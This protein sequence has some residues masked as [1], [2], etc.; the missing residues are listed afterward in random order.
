[1]SKI[2]KLTD[3]QTEMMAVYRDK[4]VK[5]GLSTEPT[6]QERAKTNLVDYYKAGDLA[7]PKTVIFAASPMAAMSI[8]SVLSS[9]T[10]YDK[11]QSILK[12]KSKAGKALANKLGDLQVALNAQERVAQTIHSSVM[13]FVANNTDI[14]GLGP[15]I[16]DVVRE[17][18][19]NTKTQWISN[20]AGGNLWPGW[21]S[22]YE[23]FNEE[24]NIPGLD[25]I[26]PTCALS[27]DV[28]WIFPYENLCVLVEKPIAINLDAA[29]RLHNNN[30]KSIE[31]SDGYGLYTLNGVSVPAWAVETPK[32]EIEPKKVLGLTN[33]E[34]RMALMRHVGL[35]KFLKELEAKQIDSLPHEDKAGNKYELYLLTVEGTTI[36]PYL[37]MKCPSSGREFLEGCGDINKYENIDTSIKTC[38]DALK[39]RAVKASNSLMTKFNLK[40]QYSA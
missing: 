2:E 37:Y 39:W 14:S 21:Q 28:G 36:G 23:F 16:M 17:E 4:W 9:D 38:E 8:L 27:Q 10:F 24:L 30:G 40:W 3:K 6:N 11:L 5:I 22:F 7:P 34:Q 15:A 35:T 13:K 12:N 20:F 31:W 25:K 32:E 19:K 1:M 18:V 26:K 33:T 29:G